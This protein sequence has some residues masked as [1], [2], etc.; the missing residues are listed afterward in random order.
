MRLQVQPILRCR[1]CGEFPQVLC[2]RPVDDTFYVRY[3]CNCG[4]GYTI[5]GPTLELAHYYALDGWN[6]S[7][8]KSS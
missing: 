5:Y 1:H 7:Y 3:Y 4:K 2:K 8:G 6:I